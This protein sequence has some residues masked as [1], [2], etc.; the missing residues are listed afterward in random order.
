MTEQGQGVAQPPYPREPN[1]H[2]GGEQEPGPGRPL[3]PYEDRQT[4]GKD[5]D[6]LVRERGGEGSAAGPREV[7]QAEREGVPATDTTGASPH[8]VGVSTRGSGNESALGDS[9]E[10]RR[11]DRMDTGLSRE[12]NVDPESPAMHSGDQGG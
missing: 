12:G 6:E 8:G 2:S 7:S 4:S 1:V 11:A 5:Q 9:E 10:E 3:P